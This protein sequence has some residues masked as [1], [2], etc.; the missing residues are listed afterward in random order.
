M[1]GKPVM[2]ITVRA[3]GADA[4]NLRVA[5]VWLNDNGKKSVSMKFDAQYQGEYPEE[6][7]NFIKAGEALGGDYW[8]NVFEKGSEGGSRGGGR[9]EDF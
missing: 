5:T 3:K 9:H 8:F 1:A 2:D 6:V 7:K 4:K